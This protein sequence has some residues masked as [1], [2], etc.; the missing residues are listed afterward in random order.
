M[1]TPE[2]WWPL[3]ERLL[4]RPEAAAE[5]AQLTTQMARGDENAFREF[6]ARYFNRLFG[7]LLVLTRGREDAAQEAL[8]SAMLRVLKHVKRFNDEP[9]FWCW[10]TVLARTALVDQERKRNRYEACLERFGQ[11]NPSAAESHLMECLKG[12][13][14]HLPPEEAALIERKYFEGESVAQIAAALNLSEKT[15]E[16]RLGRIRQK[17]KDKTLELLK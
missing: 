6:Y 3:A 13:L 4:P 15:V 14:A 16:S 9:A 11:E 2:V 7:Y 17:L 5:I 1:G 12:S 10:L 8:Q